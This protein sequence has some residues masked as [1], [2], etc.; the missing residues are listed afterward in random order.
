MSIGGLARSSDPVVPFWPL[1]AFA[2][3]VSHVAG[4]LVSRRVKP[5]PLIFLNL[6]AVLASYSIPTPPA[7]HVGK[8]HSTA[9]STTYSIDLDL[10][11]DETARDAPRRRY[12]ARLYIGTRMVVSN[13]LGLTPFSLSPHT[14]LAGV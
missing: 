10:A 2:P 12:P 1:P 5:L 4:M 6:L 7:C 11:G 3:V 9:P 14:S 8:S 13:R